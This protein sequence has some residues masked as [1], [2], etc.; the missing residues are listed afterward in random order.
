M[1]FGCGGTVL[2]AD[3]RRFFGASDPAGFILFSRNCDTPAQVSRLV[4]DLRDSVGRADAPVLIDQEG[5]RVQRLR[6]PVWPTF[7]S[8]RQLVSRVTGRDPRHLDEAVFLNA[9]LI[10]HD[11]TGLGI[12][13][14]CLPV[15]DVANPE[16]H[17]V[18]GDRAFGDIPQQVAR[19]GRVACAGLLAG[20]VLPVIKHIPGH[21]R[22]S[23]DS[24]TELPVVTASQTELESCDFLPFRLLGDMPW[25]MT[26]HVVFTALDPDHPATLS[27]TVV[28][29]VIRRQIGF[30]GL[31]CTDDL[32]M[33]AL[34][35]GF[36]DR[37][38]RALAAGCDLV[39]HCNGHMSEMTA[40]A[41][42][43]GPL[44]VR[45]QDRLSRAERQRCAGAD[46]QTFDAGAARARL[47]QM[48]GETI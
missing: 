44:S 16:T 45:A 2:Q 17:E 30:D 1:I 7:P 43:C 29:D 33:H 34:G 8:A 20:G 25:A 38:E 28:Q 27:P 5:G 15:L 35:G 40:I 6:P 12:T 42:G 26:C 3:E 21:G 14:N 22:A 9:R 13:V 10:A 31:L 18:I 24:H 39:L 4:A 32:S 23:V 46:T 47:L 41:D 19:L 11:L 37:A 36:R 48:T